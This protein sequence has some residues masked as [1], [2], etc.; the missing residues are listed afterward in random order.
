LGF[1]ENAKSQRTTSF[2]PKPN[3]SVSLL[4]RISSEEWKVFFRKKFF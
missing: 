4:P 3:E 2:D 1:Q